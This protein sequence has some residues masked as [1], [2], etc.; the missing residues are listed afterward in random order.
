MPWLIPIAA[1]AA[2][3]GFLEASKYDPAKDPNLLNDPNDPDSG[4][5]MPEKASI[6]ESS[7]EIGKEWTRKFDKEGRKQQK[8]EAAQVMGTDIRTGPQE[9]FR[10]SQADLLSALQK[11]A[12]GEGPSVATEQL[13]AARD[14]SIRQQMA[15]AASNQG[16]DPAVAAKMAAEQATQTNLQTG[17]QIAQ[18]KLQEQTAAQQQIAGLAGQA[19]TQDI[20]LAT[21]QAKMNQATTLANL[22][23]EQQQREYNDRMTQY[24][25][26]MGFQRD[27][28]IQAAQA[29][30]EKFQAQT[31]MAGEAQEA[32]HRAL[33]AGLT[34][35]GVKSQHQLIGS[36]LQ[37][38]G[39]F[40]GQGAGAIAALSDK[41][42]KKDITKEKVSS[43][44]DA[45]QSAGWTYKDPSDGEGKHY[46]VMAQDL[47]KTKVGRSMVDK[48]PDGRLGI[49]VI[50]SIGPILASLSEMKKRLDHIDAR[51]G[52]R[53]NA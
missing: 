16:V 26:S 25:M 22:Q 4:L 1:G 27:Q 29:D 51:L 23:A 8:R 9:E 14:Q 49:D 6:D 52:G 10:Q 41:R 35:E 37:V 2:G 40:L 50:D 15:A 38:G 53:G 28:A 32:Q 11:Q 3:V 19:R 20:G 18:A 21:D 13:K 31:H 7:F 48:Q 5:W 45:L 33:L 24:Y 46:G 43:F 34:Q 42:G 36:G 12:R 17:Q 47:L 30:W 39:Q 44:L